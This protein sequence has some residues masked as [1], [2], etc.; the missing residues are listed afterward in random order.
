MTPLPH[1][2][3]P[4]QHQTKQSDLPFPPPSLEAYLVLI[5]ASMPTLRPMFKRGRGHTHDAS[6]G[7]G[8]SGQ[9]GWSQSKRVK[10]SNNDSSGPFVPLSQPGSR[11]DVVALTEWTPPSDSSTYRVK[12]AGGYEEDMVERGVGNGDVDGIRRDVT[13]T[14]VYGQP[15]RG[16]KSGGGGRL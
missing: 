8:S 7:F 2:F 14:V 4:T 9:S 6:G 1:P 12:A 15:G 16:D 5:A 10:M 11:D 13:V 3:P